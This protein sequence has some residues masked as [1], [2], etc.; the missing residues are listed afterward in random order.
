MIKKSG[1][2]VFFFREIA[3]HPAFGYMILGKEVVSKLV[4]YILISI[5]K[6]FLKLSN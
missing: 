2:S 6:I 1:L 4:T 5:F 3:L